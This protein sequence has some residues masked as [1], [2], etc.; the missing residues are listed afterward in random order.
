MTNGR[1]SLN[2]GAQFNIYRSGLG[3]E[4]ARAVLR[5]LLT[6]IAASDQT[7]EW[8]AG[9]I[10]SLRTS[11]H[12]GPEDKDPVDFLELDSYDDKRLMEK[13][14]ARIAEVFENWTHDR[15]RNA[16]PRVDYR[17]A[18]VSA[19]EITRR[20]TDV[21]PDVTCN[22]AVSSALEAVVMFLVIE[23]GYDS[24]VAHVQAA[25]V[26]GMATF[27][28]GNAQRCSLLPTGTPSSPLVP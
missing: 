28:S 23:H 27:T 9:V 26:F 5:E 1:K 11:K 3:T 8:T 15:V 16:N 14:A 12:C 13:M 17:S 21:I 24:A 25:I 4:F 19:A 20:V 2:P 10:F 6:G 7:N 18:A 22:H